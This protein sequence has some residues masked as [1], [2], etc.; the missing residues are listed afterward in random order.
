MTPDDACAE[1]RE[2]GARVLAAVRAGY[3]FDPGPYIHQ[4][5]VHEFGGAH[6]WEAMKADLDLAKE[7]MKW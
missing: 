4:R 2:L 7:E 3:P 1:L 6:A 5:I